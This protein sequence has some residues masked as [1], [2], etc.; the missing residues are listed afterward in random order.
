MPTAC[1]YVIYLD[2]IAQSSARYTPDIETFLDALSPELPPNVRLIRGIMAYSVLNRPLDDDP[3]FA[4]FWKFVDAVRLRNA[5]SL[6]GMII[7]LRNVLV[8]AVS[9]D[10]RYGPM[11]NFGIAKVM[12]DALIA[13]GYRIRRGTPVT[14]IGYSGGGQMS[15]GAAPVLKRAIG[16]PVDVISLGGVISGAARI[17]ELE[18]LY[19]LVGSKDGI[20]RL[21]PI[22]FP[23]R[24]R[25]SVGSNWNRARHRGRIS[26]IPLGPVGHQVPGGMLDPD[27]TLGDGRTFLR[28]TLDDVLTILRDE[29]GEPQGQPVPAVAQPIFR[30]QTEPE[31]R[32][33][34]AAGEWV[35]RLILPDRRQREDVN[36]V[37]FEVRHAPPEERALVGRILPLR[38]SDAGHV[39]TAIRAATGDVHFSASAIDAGRRERLVLPHRLDHW[40]LVDPLE[41]LA[42]AH[43]TDDVVVRLSGI[44]DVRR[45]NG[46]ALL[47]IVREPV[48]IGGAYRALL[49]VGE[50]AGSGAARVRFFDAVRGAFDDHDEVI[51][52]RVPFPAA[53]DEDWYASGACDADGTFMAERFD[54]RATLR[55]G[56]EQ[57]GSV[58]IVSHLSGQRTFAVG[59]A[60]VVHDDICGDLRYEVVY[61]RMLPHDAVGS[62]SGASSIPDPAAGVPSR[63]VFMLA[64]SF[65]AP[66]ADVVRAQL[67]AIAARY[68]TG[69]GSGLAADGFGHPT[70]QDAVR[71]LWLGLRS[72]D[73]LTN[74]ARDLQ[75][76]LQPFA[77]APGRDESSFALVS[78]FDESALER[79]RNTLG[80]WRLVVPA[81]GASALVSVFTRHAWRGATID[82][83][84]M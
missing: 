72:S 81:R 2:G 33:F 23:S 46:A 61:H 54:A 71:A 6:L 7:N 69:D 29:V 50:P 4:A 79:A 64:P 70:A 38:W 8:V 24:W 62:I 82:R 22:M 60:E 27:R 68:R 47:F 66:V 43:E 51:R 63:D 42:G 17:L 25:V 32:R 53:S 5:A 48:Q 49:R 55:A 35:G 1:R 77:R 78:T 16:A 18:H 59:L 37:L 57:A 34:R 65:G 44:V 3:I 75:R 58:A 31:P 20:Q 26:F 45:E 84:G 28:Q 83:A 76:T 40:Q 73:R 11:Y 9:A 30:V 67:G 80:G 14:L 52:A 10:P 12:Y 36:G 56:A 13:S 21:G 41:S 39:Q 15:V 74:V 19:H